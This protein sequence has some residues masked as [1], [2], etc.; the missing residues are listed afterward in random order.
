MCCKSGEM[1]S[2]TVPILSRR[3]GP[4]FSVGLFILIVK[5]GSIWT[6]FEEWFKSGIHC[7]WSY[8]GNSTSR[9]LFCLNTHF[10]EALFIFCVPLMQWLHCSLYLG[11]FKW[12]VF[13]LES[14]NRMDHIFFFLLVSQYA[15]LTVF[16]TRVGTWWYRHDFK[17]IAANTLFSACINAGIFPFWGVLQKTLMGP[18]WVTT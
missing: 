15:L 16:W 18:T 11:N 7:P 2:P 6:P 8:K 14:P 10:L 5:D 17:S 4:L 9:S 13:V 1:G 12:V 3:K